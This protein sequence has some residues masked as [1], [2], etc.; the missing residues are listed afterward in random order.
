VVLR[1]LIVNVESTQGWKI[2]KINLRELIDVCKSRPY[3]KPG[4]EWT[5][6]SK[7]FG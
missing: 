3:P 5:E 7:V 1:K 4:V 2:W 6:G